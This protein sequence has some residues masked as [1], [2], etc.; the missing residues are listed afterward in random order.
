VKLALDQLWP[1]T[2]KLSW[3]QRDWA[4]DQHIRLHRTMHQVPGCKFK[5]MR[6]PEEFPNEAAA[7]VA[8]QA[9]TRQ[10]TSRPASF[11]EY[12][13]CEHCWDGEVIQI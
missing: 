5:Q 7:Q 4:S 11:K 9:P 13:R 10:A 12:K 2:V 1:D 8:I 3:R 6:A